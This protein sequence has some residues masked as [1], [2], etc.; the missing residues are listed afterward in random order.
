VSRCY[1]FGCVGSPGH[2]WFGLPQEW[3]GRPQDFPFEH[4][5]GKF[6]PRVYVSGYKP[7]N[8][9]EASEGQASI[10]YIN[11]N[12]HM[13]WTVLAFWDRSVDKR[14]GCNSNFIMQGRH[15]FDGAVAIAKERFPS[16]WQR[17]KFEVKEYK[18]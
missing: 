14:G 15:S 4:I 13:I 3:H 8:Y 17:F 7:Y 18:P 5:D 16:I 9:D 6:A 1:Y 12:N 11:D 2:Y 10:T